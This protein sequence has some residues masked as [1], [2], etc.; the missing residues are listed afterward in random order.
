MKSKSEAIEYFSFMKDIY[1]KMD[2]SGFINNGEVVDLC[3][4]FFYEEYA[5]TTNGHIVGRVLVDDNSPIYEPMFWGYNTQEADQA[6]G[7]KFLLNYKNYCVPNDKAINVF[8]E[9]FIRNL[10]KFFNKETTT[11]IFIRKN[12]LFDYMDSVYGKKEVTKMQTYVTMQVLPSYQLQL[13]F[14]PL[15]ITPRRQPRSTEIPLYISPRDKGNLRADNR[16]SC[17]IS[18]YYLHYILK[19]TMKDY[20]VIGIKYSSSPYSPVIVYAKNNNDK[21]KTNVYWAISQIK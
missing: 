11:S 1:N 19:H 16:D 5:Y 18:V 17:T 15:K 21:S 20:D 7:L 9:N 6:S 4:T 13:D 12:D 14:A 3:G 2:G 8:N 10:H